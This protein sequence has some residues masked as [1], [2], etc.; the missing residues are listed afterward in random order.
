M[1]EARLYD[2]ADAERRQT[3]PTQFKLDAIIGGLPYVFEGTIPSEPNGFNLV[4][5]LP[6]SEWD[7]LSPEVEHAIAENRYYAGQ[8]QKLR[9]ALRLG[10]G[11]VGSVWV[12]SAETKDGAPAIGISRIQTDSRYLPE[13]S[14]YHAAKGVGS[15][16]LDNLCALADAKGWRIYLEPLERDG[17]LTGEDLIEWYERKG[18]IFPDTAETEHFRASFGSMVRLPQ[19]PTAAQ[20][21]AEFMIAHNL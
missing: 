20:P 2:A 3:G 17:R 14:E 18:F 21:I 16:L 5:S 13:D 9:Q 19:S 11:K 1:S 12:S 4:V 15:F 8:Y 7:R 10:D 6:P